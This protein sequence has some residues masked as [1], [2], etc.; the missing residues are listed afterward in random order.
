MS[1][2]AAL[3]DDGTVAVAD[4]GADGDMLLRATLAACDSDRPV[5]GDIDAERTRG[6]SVYSGT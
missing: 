2:L 6:D 5:D 1:A 4:G 3:T